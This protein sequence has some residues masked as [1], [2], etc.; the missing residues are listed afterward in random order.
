MEYELVFIGLKW[1]GWLRDWWVS[2]LQDPTN[3][4]IDLNQSQ[5]IRDKV[6]HKDLVLEASR[7]LLFFTFYQGHRLYPFMTER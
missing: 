4:D 5:V 3:R 1:I 7:K 6:R 2:W